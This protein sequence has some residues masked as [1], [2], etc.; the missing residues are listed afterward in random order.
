MSDTLENATSVLKESKPSE[1]LR[2]V[3]DAVPA[4]IGTRL[5]DGTIE[6]VNQGWL[7]FAGLSRSELT[8]DGWKSVI[9]PDDLPAHAGRIRAGMQ[10]GALYASEV[11][12]RRADGVYRWFLNR[13]TPLRD[14]TGCIVRWYSITTDIEDTKQI[15]Y[16][17]RESER[18]LAEAQRV[19]HVGHWERDLET[20]RIEW[21]DETYR[22]FGL[23]PG[24]LNDCSML[25]TLMH[26]E[27]LPRV[28]FA[29]ERAIQGTQRYDVEYR[30]VLQDGSIRFLHS[31]GDV[32]WDES[33][34][35]RRM[36]GTVQ[37]ITQLKETQRQ[38]LALAENSPDL[39]ARF[40]CEGRYMFVN[41]AWEKMSGISAGEFSGKLIGQVSPSL[42]HPDI[43]REI[44]VL[45]QAILQVI[46]T[47]AS[48][49]M[50][51]NVR[52]DNGKRVYNVRLIPEHDELGRLASVLHVG[53]D[54]TARKRSEEALQESEE[55]CRL[56]LDVAA[57]GTWRHDLTTGIVHLDRRSQIVWGFDHPEVQ[58][59]EMVSRIHPEDFMRVNERY[60][61]AQLLTDP[62]FA[63]EC[64]V[65][66]PDGEIRWL[67]LRG[68]PYFKDTQPGEDGVRKV[69]LTIGTY[70]DITEQKRAEEELRRTQTELARVARASMVGELTASIAHE[71]NQPLAAIVT[72]ANACIRWL[73]GET[74]NFHEANEALQRIVR[75]GK[76]A[77][78]VVARIRSLLKNEMP[79][80]TCFSLEDLI[81]DIVTLT[82]GE[83]RR[84]EVLLQ[85]RLGRGL[86]PVTADRVQLQQ[87]LLNLVMNSL[88]ALSEIKGARRLNILAEMSPEGPRLSVEDT[89]VGIPPHQISRIF[90]AFYSTKAD[91]L[92]MGLS[93]SRS[94]IAAHGGRLWVQ[95]N[96]GNSPGTTFLFTLPISGNA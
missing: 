18:R 21:S 66:R 38:L 72:N 4:L 68:R 3:L 95:P 87:V 33:Q 24:K 7:D 89:G 2:L 80:K 41:S 86:P 91:G 74:P 49:E 37:D 88:D 82:E 42:T 10:A 54:I 93:I 71:V 19:A 11:R 5:P 6:F 76:R 77:S 34:Q 50:E 78:D 75:D 62:S 29:I 28:Q 8:G 15:E 60:A 96:G 35:R 58:N 56:A 85:T 61:A 30:A 43:Q 57:V 20:D 52:R 63:C 65:I 9:H 53:R 36:F 55:R 83:I 1:D 27:D 79:A 32:V 31:Q 39:I 59:V 12:V 23:T 45:S 26:P 22:I 92:G 69:A 16:V 70:L 94:I 40:D 25:F 48:S 17:L 47:G 14:E 81:Q 90:E 13:G 44:P 64:R 73:A 67:A 51:V 46:A 84:R